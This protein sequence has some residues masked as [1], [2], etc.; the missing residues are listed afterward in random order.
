M[1]YEVKR[2][3]VKSQDCY[4]Y[5]IYKDGELYQKYVLFDY[6]RAQQ[7][8]EFLSMIDAFILDRDN[9]MHQIMQLM[10][11]DK[12]RKKHGKVNIRMS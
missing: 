2:G 7:V 3:Y 5:G 6:K 8:A 1:I 4:M 10:H 9:G 11:I 12:E